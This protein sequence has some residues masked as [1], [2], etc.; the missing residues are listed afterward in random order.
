MIEEG[1]SLPEPDRRYWRRRVNR[2]VRKARRMRTL[3]RWTGIVAAN[4]SV[5][6]AAISAVKSA[7]APSNAAMSGGDTRLISSSG[8]W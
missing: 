7:T 1:H 8:R 6:A 5:S 3:L 2:H 4:G